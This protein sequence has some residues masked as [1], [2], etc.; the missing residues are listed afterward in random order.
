MIPFN[1]RPLS[2]VTGS[3]KG[4]AGLLTY[5]EA[6]GLFAPIGT[7]TANLVHQSD[8]TA[9]VNSIN[10]ALANKATLNH[11]HLISDVTGLQSALDGKA[12]LSH[13][14]AIS[15]VTGLQTALDA[16]QSLSLLLTSIAALSL[17]GNGGKVLAVKQDGTGFELVSATTSPA[18]TT[19]SALT[20]AAT[21]A[22]AGALYSTT[23]SGKTSGSTI[24][25]TASDGTTLT[26]S[27][28]TLSGTFAS[29]GT[30]T[31]T[32]TETLA[33]AT[34]T[35]LATNIS[36]TVAVAAVTL[37]TLSLSPT[38]VAM[39]ATYSATISGKTAGSTVTA[40]S[41]DGTTLTVSGT[42]VTGKFNSSG[43]PTVTLTETLAG[44]TN[45]PKAT[46]IS[47][48]VTSGNTPTLTVDNTYYAP[49]MSFDSVA[50]YPPEPVFL[51][52]A[53][54]TVGD[55]LRLEASTV[56]D[57]STTLFSQAVVLS[58]P[59]ATGNNWV[60]PGL[61]TRVSPNETFFRA[62]LENAAATKA[63]PWTTIIKHGD[64]TAPTITS[65]ST[66]SFP[67]N[68][69]VAFTLTASEP[70][71]WALDTTYGDATL[72]E[73]YN[74]NIIRLAGNALPDYEG[75]HKSYTFKVT[76]TDTGGNV[77]TPQIVTINI[78]DVYEVQ[79]QKLNTNDKKSTVFVSTDGL[80]MHGSG[81][82]GTY[83]GVRSLNQVL[84]STDVYFEV[85]VTGLAAD[86]HCDSLLGLATAAYGI[87]STNIPSPGS[88]SGND[89]TGV[90]ASFSQYGNYGFQGG[91]NYPT[92]GLGFSEL[93][94]NDVVMVRV[95]RPSSGNATMW[96]GVNGTWRG[97][98]DF[99][100][101]STGLTMQ[102]GTMAE[103]FVHVGTR[104]ENQ[105][106]VNFGATAFAYTQPSGTVTM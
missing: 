97:G 12:A 98:T 100:N 51:V 38:S 83:Q 105:L 94:L 41:S 60:F 28:T 104:N 15:S 17:P 46:T 70:V 99:T 34:N 25:A 23:I 36:V 35:P 2:Q 61:G 48:A 59:T 76:A 102:G 67:E 6:L 55:S 49:D 1:S 79:P 19:L 93:V 62:R 90:T 74:G 8:L 77:S 37:A 16:K 22:T 10:T 44:A 14:H 33:G 9:A 56:I 29:A 31:V 73:L 92:P 69:P 27:G 42:T 68:S 13:T 21:S 3:D 24:T 64:I 106:T 47:V 87:N 101:L 78:T 26:V 4:L 85:K 5:G 103:C 7:A 80:T 20:L 11:S 75:P 45:T 95:R 58:N 72:V 91:Y 65:A 43:S 86:N 32:L 84:P 50:T 53:T 52:P 57:F 89:P 82:N 63:S 39:G 88:A 81:S 66:A 18:T 30:K 71:T 54:A 96:I 40:T